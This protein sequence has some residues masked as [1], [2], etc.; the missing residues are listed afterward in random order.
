[1]QLAFS[2]IIRQIICNLLNT[3]IHY[4]IISIHVSHSKS[5]NIKLNTHN[6]QRRIQNLKRANP[7]GHHHGV[8]MCTPPFRGNSKL[9]LM[10]TGQAYRGNKGEFDF[11]ITICQFQSGHLPIWFYTNLGPR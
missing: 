7:K 11:A 2:R 8:G 5:K 10:Q 1:M 4:L 3:R 9:G 6:K